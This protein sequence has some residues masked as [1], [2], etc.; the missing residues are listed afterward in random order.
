MISCFPLPKAQTKA[1]PCCLTRFQSIYFSFFYTYHIFCRHL[2]PIQNF[3]QLCVSHM[4]NFFSPFSIRQE[5]LF[6]F[7][8]KD[9]LDFWGISLMGPLLG[10]FSPLVTSWTSFSTLQGGVLALCLSLI[11]RA[12]SRT[13]FLV[14]SV[15]GFCM[16]W[17][18]LLDCFC[19]YSINIFL[20]LPIYA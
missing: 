15:F 13:H 17:G 4:D 12:I 19:L 10:G 14:L 2:M 20:T 16:D 18:S 6:S 1:L 7:F 8:I 3:L 5:L 9:D 11:S